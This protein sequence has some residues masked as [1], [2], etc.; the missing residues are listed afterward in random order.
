MFGFL[1][2]YSLET[3]LLLFGWWERFS[4]AVQMPLGRSSPCLCGYGGVLAA[5]VT[6]PSPHPRVN[7]I[8]EQFK[9]ATNISIWQCIPLP[10][11]APKTRQNMRLQ[12]ASGG[13]R[14]PPCNLRIIACLTGL[15]ALRNG[16]ERDPNHT[17]KQERNLEE[18]FAQ[19]ECKYVF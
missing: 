11:S 18:C 13:C 4:G 1:S 7:P 8:S 16:S 19:Y 17:A 15:L 3:Q 6:A 2:P 9:G 5:A 10:S 12:G 14:L